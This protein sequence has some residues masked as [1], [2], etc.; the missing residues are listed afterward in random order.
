MIS[1]NFLFWNFLLT[2][3]T[4]P[5][6]AI[7]PLMAWVAQGERTMAKKLLTIPIFVVAFFFGTIVS[8]S[9]YALGVAFITLVS[10]N[11]A[12]YPWFYYIFGGTAAIAIRAPSGEGGIIASSVSFITYLLLVTIFPNFAISMFANVADWT[13]SLVILIFVG[14]GIFFL[15]ELISSF[16][17]KK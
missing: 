7:N 3:V 13:M 17:K 9:L 10:A 12:I 6:F 5:T 11:D 15:Y 1:F 4:I 14:F 8:C 2:I 16:F